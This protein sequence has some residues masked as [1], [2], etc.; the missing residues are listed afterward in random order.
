MGKKC[1]NENCNTYASFGYEMYKPI[2]CKEHKLNNMINVHGKKKKCIIENCNTQCYLGL[3][4][5][6]ATHC[7]EHATKDMFNVI[8]KRCEYE[9][10]NTL[11]SYGY[12]IISH[13]KKHKLDNMINIKDKN[14]KCI[15]GGCDMNPS[16]NYIN[17]KP[18]YCKKHKLDNMIITISK[19]KCIIENCDLVPYYGHESNNLTHCS[20]HKIKDMFNYKSKKCIIDGCVIQPSYGLL[21][22]KATHCKIHSTNDMIYVKNKKCINCI[23]VFANPKYDKMCSSCYFNKHPDDPRITNFKKREDAY[24]V[25][26][27]DKY[28]DIIL[29][30]IIDGGCSKRR[31]DGLIDILTHSIIIEIDED[32][33]IGK[34]YNCENKRM[35]ILF[36]DL[37]SRPLVMIRLNPDKYKIGDTIIKSSFTRTPVTGELKKN[38][39]EFN[40][41][42]E[43]LYEE[44]EYHMFN[45][46]EKE[47]SVIEL[48]YNK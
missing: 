13:C 26:L 19:R 29:D 6:K 39:K 15:A 1:T 10:C 11:P 5:K 44:I 16:Y 12:N 20:K 7:K 2:N 35:M 47:I 14:R 42:L 17:K 9:N 37:G 28:G 48:Y 18:L 30:K 45:I 33:H 3:E 40:K 36:E 23:Y 43:R 22:P 38:K 27:K 25:P 41:R 8:T 24:M 31:P 34:G 32:Q 21:W 4:W 46:P